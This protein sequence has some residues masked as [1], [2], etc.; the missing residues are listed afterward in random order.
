M[1]KHCDE[2]KRF[3]SDRG[4]LVRAFECSHLTAPPL[5]GHHH[6]W[7]TP[8]SSSFSA[9]RDGRLYL[10]ANA[11]ASKIEAFRACGNSELAGEKWVLDA[12]SR[13][14]RYEL[15]ASR[16]A[17]VLRA[18]LA[19]PQQ[20]TFA[21]NFGITLRSTAIITG[22]Y[23]FDAWTTANR[24]FCTAEGEQA[25]SRLAAVER[26]CLNVSMSEDPQWALDRRVAKSPANCKFRTLPSMLQQ[27]KV[28]AAK[29]RASNITARCPHA[30]AG[31]NQVS[32][33]YNATDITGVFVFGWEPSHLPLVELAFGGGRMPLM[34][35]VRSLVVLGVE[36]GSV[37]GAAPAGRLSCA[38]KP[39]RWCRG[40]GTSSRL[41]TSRPDE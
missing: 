21:G 32:A 35:G 4:L 28:Y 9:P 30:K 34:P 19:D 2:C 5:R 12:S 15:G 33:V 6:N 20:P 8:L 3:H 37:G 40:D 39:L 31:I 25:A 36:R 14:A 17:S 13:R 27:Q 1:Q 11:S 23:A 24:P 29:L 41:C 7:N 38:C 16:P 22:A 26:E 10:L 18:D